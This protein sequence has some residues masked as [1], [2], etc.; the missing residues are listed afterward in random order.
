MWTLYKYHHSVLKGFPWGSAAKKPQECPEEPQ[1]V[2]VRSL[3]QE[4][5]LEDGVA[6][7]PA[8]RTWRI[9][10]SEQP[11]RLQSRRLGHDS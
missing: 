1:E 4:D 6:T 7:H 3:G 8:I 2:E 11:G 9:P 5:P 10:C